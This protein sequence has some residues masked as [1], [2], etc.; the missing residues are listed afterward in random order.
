M[1]DYTKEPRPDGVNP[2]LWKLFASWVHWREIQKEE[3]E[4]EK[5]LEPYF[6]G[7]LMCP[8]CDMFNIRCGC[9]RFGLCP[10]ATSTNRGVFQC[11]IPSHPWKKYAKANTKEEKI[12]I[13]QTLK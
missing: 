6:T 3:M 9:I 11:S 7:S 1:K 4:T 12:T 5:D 8:L 10:L 13:N 2:V